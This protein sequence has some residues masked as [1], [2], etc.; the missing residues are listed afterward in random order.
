MSCTCALYLNDLLP[1]YPPSRYFLTASSGLL[2]FL[3]LTW[4]LPFRVSIVL[5]MILLRV[6]TSKLNTRV[7]NKFPTIG[8]LR[9]DRELLIFAHEHNCSTD[10]A[11]G[12]CKQDLYGVCH[13]KE[14]E[15]A[16][17]WTNIDGPIPGGNL[18]RP[19]LR[20]AGSPWTEVI[21]A[22]IDW[23]FVCRERG[24]AILCISPKFRI[25]RKSG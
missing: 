9:S 3:T 13:W 8:E 1:R 21:S 22:A 25:P 14:Q 23:C 6:T 4:I 2:L 24:S 10:I 7:A 18:M 16:S 12:I 11:R 5:R 15:V 20:P 17:L 19:A